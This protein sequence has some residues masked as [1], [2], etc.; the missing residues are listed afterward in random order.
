[1]AIAAL[2]TGALGLSAMAA[3]APAEARI[4]GRTYVRFFLLTRPLARA[5]PTSRSR[6]AFRRDASL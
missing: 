5:C 6:R 4:R 1:M 2:M 3:P